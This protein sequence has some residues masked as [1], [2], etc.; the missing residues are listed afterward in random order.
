VGRSLLLRGWESFLEGF[1]NGICL[2]YVATYQAAG[3][4]II[5]PTVLVR[6]VIVAVFH[7]ALF[8]SFGFD[9][10]VVNRCLFAIDT[11]ANFSTTVPP[12]WV[13]ASPIIRGI[14]ED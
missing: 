1:W 8:V 2:D 5:P 7:S 12:V 9:L 10:A 3:G 6:I 14:P 4:R 11:R 13:Q